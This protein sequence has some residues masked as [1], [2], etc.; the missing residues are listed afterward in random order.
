MK[1]EPLGD[2]VVVKATTAEEKKYGSLIIPDTATEKPVT[3][4]ILAVGN[5]E[6]VQKSLKVGDMVIYKWYG[7][8]DFTI[9]NEDFMVIELKDI[10]AKVVA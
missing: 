3:G 10:L 7:T 5:G 1:L 8:N 2:T 6:E 4:E 9:D